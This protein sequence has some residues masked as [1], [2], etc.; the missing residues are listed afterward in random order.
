MLVREMMQL[1]QRSSTPGVGTAPRLVHLVW[2]TVVRTGIRE[3][4]GLGI[5]CGT[6]QEAYLAA[7]DR[8]Y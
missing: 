7:I 6:E 4:L 1:L 8:S 5:G 3:G 2:D